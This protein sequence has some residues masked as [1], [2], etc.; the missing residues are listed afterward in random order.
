VNEQDVPVYWDGGY[1]YAVPT[2][3]TKPNHRKP[4]TAPEKWT[5][6]YGVVGGDFYAL[7]RSPDVWLAAPSVPVSQAEILQAAEQ[8]GFLPA[9]M[10]AKPG[11][12]VGEK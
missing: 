9:G 5:A 2:I 1:W 4:A 11:M 3:E 8:G 10:T 6:V 12:R 7:L